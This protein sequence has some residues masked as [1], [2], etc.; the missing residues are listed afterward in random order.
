MYYALII[1]KKMIQK[2]LYLDTFKSLN[3]CD[4]HGVPVSPIFFL[5]LY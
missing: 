5:Y 2:F 1:K 4:T 3:F